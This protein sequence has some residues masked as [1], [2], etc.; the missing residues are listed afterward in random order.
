MNVH[1]AVGR[2]PAGGPIVRFRE[3]RTS[4]EA[5]PND[6]REIFVIVYDLLVIPDFP[7]ES[8]SACGVG[9]SDRGYARA[10]WC[11]GLRSGGH[12]AREHRSNSDG[13]A[14]LE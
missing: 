13:A 11:G 14:R 1:N 8:R 6:I 9:W 3:T 10:S 12:A 7:D 5:R 2:H 4:A